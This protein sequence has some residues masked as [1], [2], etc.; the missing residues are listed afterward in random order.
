MYMC[1]SENTNKY[2]SKRISESKS[3][4]TMLCIGWYVEIVGG[5]MWHIIFIS[6]FV[7]L[8]FT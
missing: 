1:V 3:N 2:K 4:E 8:R 5:I 7:Y 6:L